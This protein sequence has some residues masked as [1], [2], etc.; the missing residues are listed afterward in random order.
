MTAANGRNNPGMTAPYPHHIGMAGKDAGTET[1]LISRSASNELFGEMPPWSVPHGG[2]SSADWRFDRL[3]FAWG[4]ADNVLDIRVIWRRMT[5][6]SAR[7]LKARITSHGPRAQSGN[8]RR[9]SSISSCKSAPSESPS[10][11]I[12]GYCRHIIKAIAQ[13]CLKA[14]NNSGK[15]QIVTGIVMRDGSGTGLPP[16]HN[17]PAMCF[18]PAPSAFPT[19]DWEPFQNRRKTLFQAW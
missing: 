11:D 9:S 7:F 16:S 18:E 13:L 15:P 2:T 12:M 4:Y 6:G 14:G 1:P 10:S 19:P 17:Q 8:Q 5:H 3:M